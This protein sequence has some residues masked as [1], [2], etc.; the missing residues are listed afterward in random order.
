MFSLVSGLPFYS[1]NNVFH[2]LEIFNFSDVQLDNYF[3]HGWCF[4][5]FYLKTHRHTQGLLDFYLHYHLED[6][7]FT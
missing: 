4:L 5:V 7:H 1:H 6:S 2:R 3:L